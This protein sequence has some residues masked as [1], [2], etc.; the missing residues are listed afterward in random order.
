[1]NTAVTVATLVAYKINENLKV[2]LDWQYTEKKDGWLPEYEWNYVKCVKTEFRK[3]LVF[4][5][6]RM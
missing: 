5:K 4:G 1:V 3:R 2:V 6:E